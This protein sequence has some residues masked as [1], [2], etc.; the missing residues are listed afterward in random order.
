MS[1]APEV[2]VLE[3]APHRQADAQSAE[4]GTTVSEAPGAVAGH[5]ASISAG[6]RLV[7]ASGESQQQG[8]VAYVCSQG[9][10]E[11][12]RPVA[13]FPVHSITQLGA[14]ALLPGFLQD[15]AKVP[16]SRWGLRQHIWLCTVFE[17][18]LGK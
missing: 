14:M 18:M 3:F 1:G 16:H 2:P 10:I 13:D 4:A 5:Q 12:W 15:M 9:S 8:G 6:S 17:L 11:G 7:Q